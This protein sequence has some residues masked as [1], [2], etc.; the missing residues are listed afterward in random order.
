MFRCSSPLRRLLPALLLPAALLLGH[1]LPARAGD[2]AS[3]WKQTL[4]E[5]WSETKIRTQQALDPEKFRPAKSVEIGVAYGTEKK[6]WL[7]W[8]VGEFA[9]TPAGKQIK[10]DLIPMGSIEGARA[11]LAKDQRIH[12]WSPAS[13]VVE[14]MLV[15]PWERENNA[16]PI[17]SDAPLALTPMVIVMWEDRYDAFLAKYG[18]VN[19]KTIAEALAEPTGW[20]AIASKPEWGLFTFGHTKPTHS[21]SGLLSLVLMAH[22]YHAV[23]RGLKAEQVMD[24]GFLAWLKETESAM[25]VDE[26]STGKLM[27]H[28]LQFGPSE[29]NGVM[30]YEN[31]ALEGLHT[32]QGRWG[33]IKVIY[34]SRTVWND[35]PF[36]ILDVPWS[37]PDQRS[38]ARLFQDF[39]LSAE[40]Q[41]VARDQYLFR[42]ANLDVPIVGGGSAFDKLQDIVKLD[43]PA[44]QKP[45]GEVLEQLIQVWKRTQ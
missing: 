8:A 29:L 41:R 39:L 45:K 22:D 36:Y 31:L 27:N 35:N 23:P 17:V 32:A 4:G 34:P 1:S 20:A 3:E 42:P 14:N 7:E 26:E 44:I 38:A 24:A 28:M 18:E 15:E 37:S 5:L 33:K 21:N 12:A 13:S 43:V 19:F 2:W 9:K 10:I 6:K 16:S 25:N 30:V 40:A 11:V